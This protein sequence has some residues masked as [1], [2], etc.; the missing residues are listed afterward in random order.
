MIWQLKQSNV[1]KWFGLGW[2]F[3]CQSIQSFNIPPPSLSNPWAFACCL[4]TGGGEFEPCLETV[5]H[6]CFISHMEEL[7]GI[8][9]ESTFIRKFF[10]MKNDTYMQ[11]TPQQHQK[12]LCGFAKFW[13][14]CW[15]FKCNFG[16]GA[17]I[18]TYQS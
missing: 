5:E 2:K 4:C 10:T 9:K 1:P 8:C 7:K 6:K 15:V 17:G 12:L 13:I 11:W 16:M 14:I 18:C 3:M